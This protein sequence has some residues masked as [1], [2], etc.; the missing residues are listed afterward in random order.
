MEIGI[1]DIS[2]QGRIFPVSCLKKQFKL[3]A[4]QVVSIDSI[5]IWKI[6]NDEKKDAYGVF[7]Y[8]FIGG[9]SHNLGY[10]TFFRVTDSSMMTCFQ[11]G[12]HRFRGLDI[13]TLDGGMSAEYSVEKSLE[14]L[15]VAVSHSWYVDSMQGGPRPVFGTPEFLQRSVRKTVQTYDDVFGPATVF[16]TVI[17]STGIP[18]IPYLS[19]TFNA[20]VLPLHFLASV[21]ST[22]EIQSIMDFSNQHGLVSYATLGYDLSVGPAVAWIKLLDLP[23]VYVEFLRRHRVAYILIAGETVA[24]G[25]ETSAKQV[26]NGAVRPYQAGSIYIMRPGNTTDDSLTLAGKISDFGQVQQSESLV[27]ITDWESGIVTEQISNISNTIK[28]ET[29]ADT[30]SLTSPDLLRLYDLSS[31][32]TAAFLKKNCLPIAGV[33]LNPY[34]IAH[35]AYE[36]WK[37]LIPLNYWQGNSPASTIVRLNGSTRR[38]V[39]AYFPS[40]SWSKLKVW[41]NSSNNFGGAEEAGKLIRV[42]DDNGQKHILTNDFESN[43]IWLPGKGMQTICERIAMDLTS[44]RNLAFYRAWHKHLKYLTLQDLT[45]IIRHLPTIVLQK[46]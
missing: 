25:G 20:P 17:L 40:A 31:Y 45:D 42:L 3:N 36:A 8:C 24:R 44:G 18:S 41:V 10:Q 35:P 11:I 13:F 38:A 29:G 9:V 27:T 6:P 19:N 26:L 39:E 1:R 15:D 34:L 12:R 32:L 7:I 33:A 43:E 28:A 4:G 16:N 22:Q 30:Y 46:K 37:G 5:P 14:D 2:A 21:N 23:A